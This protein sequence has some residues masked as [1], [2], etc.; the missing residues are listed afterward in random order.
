VCRDRPADAAEGIRCGDRDED[1]AAV[2]DR[3]IGKKFSHGH[4]IPHQD[5]S[6]VSTR[7]S[8]HALPTL[9]NY[10]IAVFYYC[11]LGFQLCGGCRRDG[12]GAALWLASGDAN[13]RLLR[14]LF[15]P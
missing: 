3:F 1:F 14:V 11:Y 2:C 9:Y 13:Q 15:R 12:L 10:V 8:L 6:R 5:G 7:G 4:D